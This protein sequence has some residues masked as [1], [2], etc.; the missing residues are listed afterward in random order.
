VT[1]SVVSKSF[2]VDPSKTILESFNV[3]PVTTGETRV[4]VHCKPVAVALLAI[5]N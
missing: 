1:V 2:A 4:L 5:K 3:K